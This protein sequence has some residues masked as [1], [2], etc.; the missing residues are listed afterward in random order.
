MLESNRYLKTI[1]E[2]MQ[3]GLMVVDREGDIV[4]VNRAMEE[5]TGYRRDELIGS[6]CSILECDVCF[7]VRMAGRDTHCD[8]L[9]PSK[10]PPPEMP[11]PEK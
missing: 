10:N 2:T 8:P 1:I 4:H 6:H 3:D 7:R 5:L 9:C 11:T